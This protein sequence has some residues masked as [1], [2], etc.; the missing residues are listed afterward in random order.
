MPADRFTFLSKI[1]D[2]HETGAPLVLAATLPASRC[3]SAE[4][5]SSLTV[6]QDFLKGDF[7]QGKGR[8]HIIFSHAHWNPVQAPPF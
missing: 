1:R 8:A 6:G 7:G 3:R 4:K 5:T 2:L